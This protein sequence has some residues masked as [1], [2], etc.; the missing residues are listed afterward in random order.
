MSTIADVL[1]AL[2]GLADEAFA[3]ADAIE[4][5][6]ADG[7]RT[8]RALSG[9]S[10]VEPLVRSA[11]G[12]AGSRVQGAGFVPAI[13]LLEP[14]RWW[15]EWFVRED[16]GRVGRLEVQRDPTAIGFYD[17]AHSPWYA[18]PQASH[19]RHITGPYVDN[20]CTDDYTLTF[21]QP[22]VIDGEFLGV[23]G[24]DVGVRT[25]ERELLPILRSVT[26]R[27]AVV[28]ADGR[29]LVSNTGALMCGDLVGTEPAIHERAELPGLPLAV[30]SLG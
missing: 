29:V 28:N 26:P 7:L 4:G 5:A 18:V 24:A 23:S 13:G 2:S 16:D 27:A 19:R 22:L 10:G 25:A 9:L 8:D 30:I 20:L 21:T 1:G 14:E 6:A 11:I 3:L 17:Y 12:A 15:L